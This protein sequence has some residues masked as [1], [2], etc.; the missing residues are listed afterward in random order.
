MMHRFD[1]HETA[2]HANQRRTCVRD[3]TE[4]TGTALRD[5]GLAPAHASGSEKSVLFGRWLVDVQPHMPRTAVPADV[6]IDL[7]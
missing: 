5:R 4:N 7:C 2:A 3:R 1:D 6:A